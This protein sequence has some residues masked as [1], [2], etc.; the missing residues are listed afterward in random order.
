[1]QRRKENIFLTRMEGM[2]RIIVAGIGTDVGKTVASAILV[3]ALRGQYW[4]PVQCGNLDSTDSERVQKLSGGVW[5]PEIYL[6]EQAVSAH[7]AAALE[8]TTIDPTEMVI[9][10]T[11]KNLIIEMA[12]GLLVPYT[13]Q[14]LQLDLMRNWQADWML[15]SKHYIGSINHTLLAVEALH[16]RG[17]EIKAVIFNGPHTPSSERVIL[18][19][20]KAKFCL[21]IYNEENLSP[22]V[23]NHYAKRWKRE[24]DS[25]M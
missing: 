7:Y 22:Q 15:V 4:K 3:K 19:Y 25:Y 20:A 1:M 17:I 8:G 21:R 2:R 23:I 9:P 13:D 14:V 6:F 16:S 10:S 24:C 11:E 18:A 5:Y 12:G